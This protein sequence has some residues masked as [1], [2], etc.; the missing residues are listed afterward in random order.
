[1][2]VSTPVTFGTANEKCQSVKGTLVSV[3]DQVEQDFITS[4]LPKFP[5]SERI[6]IGLKI[7]HSD[8]QWAD[9]S[10]VHY[11]NFNPLLLGMHKSIH[12]NRWDPDSI[13]L[14]VYLI[15]NPN[16]AMLGTWDYSSCTKSQT[17]LDKNLTWFEAL[18]QCRSKNM[19]LA[20]VADTFLQSMLT[21]YVSRARKPMWIGLF[22][23]DD[24]IHYRWTDLSH[25]MFSRWSSDV[26]SGSCVYLD[27]DGFWK[28]TECEEELSGAICHKYQEEVITTPEDLAA[29]CPHKMNGPNWIPFR[30][31][32]YSFQL[33][34]SRWDQ[35]EQSKIQETC[36]K[37]HPDANILTIRNAEENE[38]I[39]QQLLPFQSLVQF[40]WLGLFKDNNGRPDVN[41][42]FYAGLTTDGTWLLFS[43]PNLFSEFKQRSIVACKL[44][45]EPN[46]EYN[47]T[48]LN[49]QYYGNLTYQV[50]TQKLTW[51]Q[52][53]E[54]CNPSSS[55][56]KPEASCV[57]VTPAG[58]WVKSSCSAVAE[59][60]I[61]YRTNITTTS[62]NAQLLSIK[63]K[64]E[65]DFVSRY[66]S[67]DPLITNRVWLNVDFDSQG[68]PVSWRDGSA[69]DFSKWKKEATAAGKETTPNCAVM[70][71]RDEGEWSFASCKTSQSRVVC[72]T[73]AKSGGSPVALGLF[74][75]ILLAL[76]A[77][78]GF[79]IYKKKQAHFSSTVRYKRTFDE[80]DTTSIITDAD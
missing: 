79:I 28:T 21:V 1:M 66:I 32:C 35:V 76:L 13:D 39:K 10:P 52:A 49:F 31:N 19:D 73:N 67:E 50:A 75:I 71:A 40:V 65:N 11:I 12:I 74:I 77:V 25:T 3:A 27:T 34:S 36:R 20:S 16:S 45:N 63:T 62:Q 47:K 18:E 64:E 57:Q 54:E 38:F 37:I 44:D 15:N 26:T 72:K 6:W 17:L 61:C 53:V 69:L 30:N 41:S 55:S 43:N 80:S 68:K 14:C 33:V 7:K 29:K 46:H 8:P 23:E 24:G 9:Q 56:D 4:L 48:S 58:D 5:N 60:A 2:R 51:Y 70:M 59:G 22:S 78:I 42:K